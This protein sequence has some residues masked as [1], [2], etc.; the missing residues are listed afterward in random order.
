MISLY[1]HSAEGRIA[2]PKQQVKNEDSTP[3]LAQSL[4]GFHYQSLMHHC[5]CNHTSDA[6]ALVRQRFWQV[7]LFLQT[8]AETTDIVKVPKALIDCW[9]SLL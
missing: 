9:S 7:R 3:A 4:G 6:L 5:L 2:E 8:S 1:S